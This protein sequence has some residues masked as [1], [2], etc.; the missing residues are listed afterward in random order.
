[1]ATT[2]KEKL[3]TLIKSSGWTPDESWKIKA[4]RWSDEEIVNPDVFV[5]PGPDGGQWRIYLVWQRKGGSYRRPPTG[6]LEAV[7]VEFLPADAK[8]SDSGR[9]IGTSIGQLRNTDKSSYRDSHLW[10]ALRGE[11]KPN[12]TTRSLRETAELLVKDPD[13][14]IWLGFQAAYDHTT[15][16]ARAD[17]RRQAEREL[18]ARPLPV[19]CD[20]GVSG[21][22]WSLKYRLQE[23]THRVRAADGKTDLPKVVADVQ[24]A[25]GAIIDALTPEARDQFHA[26]VLEAAKEV[27]STL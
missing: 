18:R 5:H 22:W 9:L 8:A 26:Y 6:T 23:A 17:A 19:T 24:L 1:M 4:D 10:N 20:Q 27:P 3:L 12:G 21:Q 25:L 16:V 11:V 14:A 2:A 13:T 15:A 7:E